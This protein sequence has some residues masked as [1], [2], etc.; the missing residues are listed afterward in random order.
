MKKVRSYKV[1]DAKKRSGYDQNERR[2]NALRPSR[3]LGY[4]HDSLGTHLVSREAYDWATKALSLDPDNLENKHLIDL[5]ERKLGIR[6]PKP[7]W[8]HE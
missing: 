8:V 3:Y 6:E 1:D 2:E 5:L 7:P 4:D